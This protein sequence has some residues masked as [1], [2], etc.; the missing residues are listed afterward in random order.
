[1]RVAGTSPALRAQAGRRSS[2]HPLNR[3]WYNQPVRNC[4]CPRLPLAGPRTAREV[5]PRIVNQPSSPA[6]HENGANFKPSTGV[7]CSEPSSCSAIGRTQLTLFVIAPRT[8]SYGQTPGQPP[9]PPRPEARHA[10]TRRM[11]ER[12]ALSML[13]KCSRPLATLIFLCAHGKLSDIE[14]LVESLWWILR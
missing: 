7:G 3:S 10:E 13:P 14:A 12:G 5:Q 4:I 9:P 8:T 1:M 2:A 6:L 11:L